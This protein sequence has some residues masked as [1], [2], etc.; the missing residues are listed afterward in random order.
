ML[1]KCNASCFYNFSVN[2]AL[3]T[4]EKNKHKNEFQKV[5]NAIK[6][7]GCNPFLKKKWSRDC[8]S[9]YMSDLSII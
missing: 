1:T 2:N 9:S 7:I 6:D 5:E 4:I 3:W 8:P